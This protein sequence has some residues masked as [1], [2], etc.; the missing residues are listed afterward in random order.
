M[1]EE[2]NQK[3]NEYCLENQICFITFHPSYSYEEFVEGIS[4]N[5]LKENRAQ[6]DKDIE[7]ILKPG[8]F[9]EMCKH[10]LGSA[11][12]LSKEETEQQK[13]IEVYSNYCEQDGIDFESAP[14]YVLIIDEINRG[15][16]AKIFGELITLLEADKRIGAE[17]E[18]IVELPVS[19]DKRDRIPLF[20]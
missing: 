17:N 6:K 14:R 19:G 10:A 11:L 3:Y 13:W 5:L 8:I 7:Y 12:G 1:S 18:I 2:R 9:K 20:E 15:D 4:V 16:I